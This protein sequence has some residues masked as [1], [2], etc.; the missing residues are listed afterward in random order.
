[1][2]EVILLP[3]EG[4]TTPISGTLFES[5]LTSIPIILKFSVIRPTNEI[6][7][8]VTQVFLFLLDI[9]HSM[10]KLWGLAWIVVSHASDAFVRPQDPTLPTLYCDDAKL[11][12]IYIVYLQHEIQRIRS[13]S[14]GDFDFFYALL[15]FPDSAR[16]RYGYKNILSYGGNASLALQAWADIA[17]ALSAGIPKS[18]RPGSP[19][20]DAWLYAGRLLRQT[21]GLIQEG[22]VDPLEICRFLKKGGLVTS[23]LR[24]DSRYHREDMPLNNGLKTI[25]VC[26]AHIIEELGLLLSVPHVL[27][28]FYRSSL[29]QVTIDEGSFKALGIEVLSQAW[30]VTLT[31]YNWLRAVYLEGK[32]EGAYCAN[33]PVSHRWSRKISA[34]LTASNASSS[35]LSV[36]R[37]PTHQSF[38][39]CLP[40]TK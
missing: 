1:M 29:P 30:R 4:S 19:N 31:K 2:K 11:G 15:S 18:L 21:L 34:P 28:Q 13:A 39:H 7:H 10:V 23:L 20:H 5:V 12:R 40:V 8:L 14:E 37:F 36:I 35:V 32:R 25:A 27:R 26:S 3:R 9:E 16:R 17:R 33:S 22:I 24:I 38:T 6:E